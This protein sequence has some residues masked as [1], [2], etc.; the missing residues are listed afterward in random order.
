MAEN[1]SGHI[2][3][4]TFVLKDAPVR[5]VPNGAISLV[6][7]NGDPIDIGGGGVQPGDLAAVATSG[8]YSDLTG[9]PTLGTA[10]AADASA[11]AT[12]AQGGL[13]ASAVQPGDLPAF[14]TAASADTGDFATAAQGAAANTAVQPSDLPTFGTAASADVNDFLAT[15]AG[16]VPAYSVDPADLAAALVRAGLMQAGGD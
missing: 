8:A 1:I 4:R 15:P 7:D 3:V 9:T 14:G 10:A 5:E 2:P 6:D 16:A 13:A 11:F 12:S